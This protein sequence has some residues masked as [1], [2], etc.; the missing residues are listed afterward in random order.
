MKKSKLAFLAGVTVA[1]ALFLA[2]CGSSSKSSQTNTYSYV[3]ST[4][5]DS[6]NYLLSN[7]STTSDVT[8][9][10]VDGLFEND[11]YGNL[12]PALAENWSVSKDGLNCTGL[13]H[14]SEICSRQQVRCPLLGSKLSS[15]PG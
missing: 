6:L 9:N 14:F 7:R 4:D 10:L 2:S 5:P 15:R 8:T 3:F 11:Q 12:V 1:S 13:R